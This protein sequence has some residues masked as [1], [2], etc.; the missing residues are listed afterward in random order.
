MYKQV[1]NGKS[2]IK[3]K[4]TNEDSGDAEDEGYVCATCKREF[5][6]F[7]AGQ[8]PNCKGWATIRLASEVEDEDFDNDESDP[9][10][11]ARPIDEINAENATRIPTGIGELDR[12]LG[13][14]AVLGGVTLVGGDPGVGKST[15]L[16]Q[17]LASLSAQGVLTL[18]VTGEESATQVSARGLRIG[19]VRPKNLLL[20]ASTDAE[21]ILDEIVRL[22]PQAAVIDSIQT[23]RSRNASGNTGSVSQV[24]EVTRQVVTVTRKENVATFLV[25]HVTKD[26]ELA[27]PKALEHLVDTVLA[28]EGERAQ[29]FRTLRVQKNRYGSSTEV[30]IFE[31]TPEGMRE[32]ANPSAFF[33]AE[34]SKDK[35]GSIIAATHESEGRSMLV[36]V[37]AL[38]GCMKIG[39]GKITSNGINTKRL[40][41]LIGVLERSLEDSGKK[42]LTS[43]DIFV[44]IAGGVDIS[45]PAL[46]L[47]IALAI[48]SSLAKMPIHPELVAFGEIGLTGEIRG[49]PKVQARLTEAS[50]MGF[51]GAIVPATVD[52]EK[53]EKEGATKRKT[54]KNRLNV[55]PVRTLEEAIEAALP[56]AILTQKRQPGSKSK[57]A[58]RVPAND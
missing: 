53:A 31:M 58:S 54:S 3:P 43:R 44:S 23:I 11:G 20:L 39:G 51:K 1:E 16:L 28:F 6:E 30:G 46:D 45:E 22:Q 25:G 50:T 2:R 24:I 5:D 40:S 10:E 57:K 27:G 17:A 36:E 38:V 19:D 15:L 32:V 41:M 47:P 9:D 34:R 26:R 13:G 56:Q 42:A 52:I 18:Y 8:C 4:E 49:V 7:I 12:V 35:P 48:V 29:A 55:L 21:F 37:Q 14:G 33:L